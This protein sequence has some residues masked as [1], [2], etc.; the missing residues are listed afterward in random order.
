VSGPAAADGHPQVGSMH[1]NGDRMYGIAGPY[2]RVLAARGTPKLSSLYHS[3]VTEEI[4]SVR[5]GDTLR[6]EWDGAHWWASSR[7]GRVGRLTWSKGLRDRT[8]YAPDGRSPYDFD[9][10]TLHVQTVTV[11][12]AGTV[13]DCGGY[14]IPD[15]H[16]PA[17]W[18]M[19]PMPDPRERELRVEIS[20]Q[21]TPAPAAAAE[22]TEQPRSFLSRL[23]G[24]R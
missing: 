1:K 7:A 23:F 21:R 11:D 13:V 18:P 2:A 6:V 14:V 5:V 17:D 3:T 9:D 16:D 22:P 24:R 20:V 4:R 12:R 19:T 8:A 15:E 10:G